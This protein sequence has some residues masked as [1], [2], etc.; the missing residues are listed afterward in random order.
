MLV[1]HGHTAA[2]RCLA[3]APDGRFLA[4]GGD[5]L[6]VRLWDMTARAE[7][8]C[9]W[10]GGHVYSV[11]FT[12]TGELLASAGMTVNVKLWSVPS[13]KKRA[14][15]A[16][17]HALHFPVSVS[18]APDS[19]LLAVC[20]NGAL[21]V[22]DLATGADRTPGAVSG[23]TH[24]AVFGPAG[25]VLALVDGAGDIRLC[26]VR[27]DTPPV[28]LQVPS[29][30]VALAFSL[31]GASLATGD[32]AEDVA[33]WDVAGRVRRATRGGHAG[34]SAVAFAP[35]GRTLASA[36]GD[37]VVRFWDVASGHERAALDW[38]IGKV[39]AVAFAPD[40]MTVAAA[41]DSPAVVVWDVE[42]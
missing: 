2:V 17:G 36:G 19:A 31:D 12:H 9:C 29:Y 27:E 42:E 41:G 4:S 11:A 24:L 5:D 1:L 21:R 23:S 6:T 7:R 18:A 10:H 16:G 32:R 28:V 39:H 20:V 40:G 35:D 3:F 37:G 30:V 13:G 25:D 38:Q 22:R 34:V 14:D 33:V 15:I 8:A 26:K